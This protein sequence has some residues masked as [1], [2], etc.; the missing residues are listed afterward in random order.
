MG[1]TIRAR[2]R[3]GPDRMLHLQLPEDVEPGEVDVT[4]KAAATESNGHTPNR[5]GEPD[6]AELEARIERLTRE[7]MDP[8][9]ELPS[10]EEAARVVAEGTGALRDYDIDLDAWYRER[11]EDDE[12]R[13]RAI[14][15]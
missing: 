6:E 11:L 13:E 15:A 14:G 9:R 4:V 1:R 10:L 12:R 7:L 8:N 2:V 3:I 5:T